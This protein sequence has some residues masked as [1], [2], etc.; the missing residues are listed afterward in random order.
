MKEFVFE[1]GD[2]INL[3]FGEKDITELRNKY[4]CRCYD[5]ADLLCNSLWSSNVLST[6]ITFKRDKSFINGIKIKD[7]LNNT[8]RTY[9]HHSV[10]LLGSCILDLIHTDRLIS[11][12]EYVHTLLKLNPDV[13]VYKPMR[14]GW[15]DENGEK[16]RVDIEYLLNLR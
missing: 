1:D 16:I 13:Y 14:H 5:L 4:I 9:T 15:Y 10:V 12:S 11:T 8:I 2:K 6:V 3:L 7:E